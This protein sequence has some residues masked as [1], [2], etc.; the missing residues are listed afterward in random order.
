MFH[1]VW[2]YMKHL[3][4]I[5]SERFLLDGTQRRPLSKPQIGLVHMLGSLF[6]VEFILTDFVGV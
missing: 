4:S 2:V 3:R 1:N 6:W 5:S